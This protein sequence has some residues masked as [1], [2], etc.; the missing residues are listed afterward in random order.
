MTVFIYYLLHDTIQVQRYHY[1]NRWDAG[2]VS[3]S[4]IHIRGGTLALK[5]N[6]K[7]FVLQKIFFVLKFNIFGRTRQVT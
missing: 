7:V 5:L 2:T 6:W 4:R 3:C 1:A